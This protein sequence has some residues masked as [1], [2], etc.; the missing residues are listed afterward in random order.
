MDCNRRQG[1]GSY[2]DKSTLE[3]RPLSELRVEKQFVSIDAATAAYGIKIAAPNLEN[4]VAGSPLIAIQE[5][6]EVDAAKSEVQSE[7][8]EVEFTS[9][10][11]GVVLKADMI[12]S[13]EAMIKL[14]EDA[15]IPVRKAEVGNVTK[16]DI[17][18][19]QNLQDKI[20]KAVLAFNVK[21]LGEAE[22]LAK[23]LGVTIFANN[24]IYRLLDEYKEWSYKAKEREIQEKL[25]QASRPCVVKILKGFIFRVSNP[26]I[27]GVEVQKGVLMPGIRMKRADG[28]IVGSVKTIEKEGQQIGEAKGGDRVAI[29]MDEPTVG[30]QIEEGDVLS[31]A[32]TENDVKLL[33]EVFE[34]LSA[35]ERD[36]LKES[37]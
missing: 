16:Q 32:L 2:K 27:F 18:E 28:K 9:E 6:K 1:T 31:A 25:S 34:Y 24:I 33:K 29:S 5:E 15:G 20:R 22:T 26:A 7:I 10:K 3:P 19:V 36:L 30:R 17:I 35:D 13:L 8:E 37:D 14:V 11:E 23:D 12:G 4:V 21:T